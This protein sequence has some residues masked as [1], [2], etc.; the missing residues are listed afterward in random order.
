[1]VQDD[2][3]IEQ[4]VMTQVNV[5]IEI[6]P[7]DPEAIA[8]LRSSTDDIENI[9]LEYLYEYPNIDTPMHQIGRS[10]ARTQYETVSKTVEYYQGKNPY[11]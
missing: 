1:M 9:C 8:F 3:F 2:V 7:P 10:D 5:T 11:F 6:T 4:N